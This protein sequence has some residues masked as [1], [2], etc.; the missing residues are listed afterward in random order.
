MKIKNNLLYLDSGRQVNYKATPNKGSAYKPQFLVMHYTASVK[1]NAVISWF[2][3]PVS[4]A[5][6][7]LLIDR[8]GSLTQFAPFNVVTWHAGKSSWKGFSG[9]NQYSIGVEMVN[10]GRLMKSGNRWICPV[11][12]GVIPSN[13]VIMAV[14]KNETDVAAWQ[15]YSAAQLKRAI[16]VVALLVHH[17]HLSDVMGHD[18]IAPVRKSDPG[19]AFPMK[20]FRARVMGLEENSLD[21]YITSTS[22]NIRSGAGTIFNV[23]GKPL[24]KGTHVLV[25]KTKGTWSFVEVLETVNGVMDLEG[26]VSSRYL[27]KCTKAT[28]NK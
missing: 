18:D 1:G 11:D 12:L 22:L 16:E 19:P 26:W 25:L 7:H 23:L 14:H 28:D 5:A 17:Y 2:L 4:R 24:P 20:T 21:E 15:Q 3:N 8:D 6:A 9:M 27:K 10:A 13:E